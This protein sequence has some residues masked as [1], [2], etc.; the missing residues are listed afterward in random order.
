M[1]IVIDQES[2]LQSIASRRRERRAAAFES[3]RRERRAVAFWFKRYGVR[4]V[5]I[6]GHM[7]RQRWVHERLVEHSEVG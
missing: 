5:E 2:I 1:R 6:E 4:Y 3:R 7:Y